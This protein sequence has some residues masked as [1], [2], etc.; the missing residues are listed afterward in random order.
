MRPSLVTMTIILFLIDTSSSMNQ[1]TYL[2]A[3]PTLLDVAKDA[4]E[5]FLKA[6]ARDMASR[7][8]RYMLL[9]FEDPPHNIKA[10]WKE[11]HAVFMNELKHLVATGVTNMGPALKNA[12]D[13][14]NLNRMQSGI[15]TYGV[16]RAPYYLEPSMIIVITD[17]SSLTHQNGV[18]TSLELPMQNHVVPGSEL[19]REP[20][21]WDQRLFSLVLRLTG[22]PPSDSSP[23]NQLSLTSDQH[24]SIGA[25]CAVT[26]GRSYT[27][28]TQRS[29]LQS[30]DALVQK[31]QS[32]VVI[33][34]EKIGPDPPPLDNVNSN[35][36]NNN[37]SYYYNHCSYDYIK[38]T[39]ST[40]PMGAG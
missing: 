26:A 18:Q 10:G 4:V 24:S 20:F 19:T 36:N 31:V 25:M 27:I 2:G 40:G 28:T 30:I 15:D 13:L 29:I 34:F 8:D 9:T 17:G 38:G 16:G 14:L 39:D 12:F 33:Q 22:S 7:G 5:K 21:R 6:R 23:S 1:R 37:K 11:S 35:N 32:G 3:R